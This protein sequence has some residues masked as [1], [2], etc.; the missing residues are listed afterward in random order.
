MDCTD[1]KAILSG[2]VDDELDRDAR[3]AAERHMVECKPCRNLVNEAEGIT[4]L[5]AID[6]Q[7]LIAT[8]LPES[9][10]EAVLSRT[11]YS[12]SY[13]LRERR[14]RWTTSMGW[15]A[16]AACLALSGMIFTLDR[17]ARHGM[18][19]PLV[20]HDDSREG[21]PVPVSYHTG[22]NLQNRPF[23][24][25]QNLSMVSSSDPGVSS[26]SQGADDD[27]ADTIHSAAVVLGMLA[28]ADVNSFADVEQ[29]RRITEYDDLLPR[30]AQ[31]RARLAETDRPTVLAAEAVLLRVVHGP[32]STDDV[33]NLRDTVAQL[34][35]PRELTGLSGRQQLASSSL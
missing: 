8:R 24:G 31:T 32:L 11:V 21:A 34:D 1:I 17:Q 30:L 33:R 3:Y 7:N 16:A 6:A 23:D 20:A 13:S 25:F 26:S 27:D 29:I 18:D 2:L 5:V 19:G 35:L 4:E 15:L 9:F 14:R 28:G 10:E 12:Q 22:S